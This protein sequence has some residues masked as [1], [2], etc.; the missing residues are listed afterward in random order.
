MM[1]LLRRGLVLA[2]TLV[3]L[4]AAPDLRAEHA[5]ATSTQKALEEAI[6]EYL[7]SHPEVVIEVFDILQAR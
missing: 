5:T 4:L 2:V 7:L 6:H 3:A 1:I